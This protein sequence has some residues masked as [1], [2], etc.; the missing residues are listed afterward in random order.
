MAPRTKNKAQ[1]PA[2]PADEDGTPPAASDAPLGEVLT[3]LEELGRS[4]GNSQAIIGLYRSVSNDE[5][6][7][8]A[9]AG[10]ALEILDNWGEDPEA[11]LEL[12][13]LIA[14]SLPGEAWALDRLKLSYSSEGRWSDLLRVLDRAIEGAETDATRAQLVEDAGRVAKDFARDLDRATRYAEQLFAIRGDERSRGALEKLYERCGKH[15]ALVDL[16]A[17]QIPD[18]LP[19]V[20]QGLRARI[21]TLLLSMDDGEAAFA[22]IEEMLAVDPEHAPAFELCERIFAAPTRTIPPPAPD[23]TRALAPTAPP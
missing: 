3:R 12:L 23:S 6:A 22:R 5:A 13:E 14:S 4:A 7:A 2:A 8:R 10:R 17:D 19:D 18:A 21:A 15:D 1:A 9:V 16:L 11:V 20:A